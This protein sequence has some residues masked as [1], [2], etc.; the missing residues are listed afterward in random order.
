LS[1]TERTMAETEMPAAA[2]ER[3]SAGV[4]GFP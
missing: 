3:M 1:S 4:I 2:T